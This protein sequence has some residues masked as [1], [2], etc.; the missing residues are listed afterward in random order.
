MAPLDE[1]LVQPYRVDESAWYWSLPPVARMRAEGLRFTTPVTVLVG[2]NGAGKS[3]LVEAIATAWEN[4]LSGAQ[5]RHWSAGVWLL[6]EPEAALSFSST[7]SARWSGRSW[8]SSGTGGRSSTDRTA[9]CGTCGTEWP[10]RAVRG[11]SRRCPAMIVPARVGPATTAP[12]DVEPMTET[13]LDALRHTVAERGDALAVRTRDDAVRW[14]WSE[15]DGLARRAA[16]GLAGLGVGHGSVVALLLDNRPEFHVADLGAVL[17][18]AATV[19]IYNTSS[20]EQ[21]DY[22]LRDSGASVLITQQSYLPAV[23]A[24]AAAGNDVRVVVLDGP[25]ADPTPGW[26]DLLAADPVERAADVTAEDLLTIIYT[27]GTTGPP[28]GVELTHRN[29]LSA[30]RSIGE[31]VGL[32]AG[33]RVICWLPLAHIAERDASYYLAVLYGLE[34]TTCADPRQVGAA[35]REVRPHFFFAVPRIWEKLKAGAEA[36]IAGRADA[37]RTVIES[38]VADAT[39]A[40]RLGQAGDPVPD[41]LAGR[42][43]AAAPVLASLRAALGLDEA[44][45]ANIGA[46]PSSPDLAL[47]FLALGIPLAE[48]YGMSENCAACTCNPAGAIRVGTAGPPL[49]GVELRI[50]DDGEVLM[51]S[52]AVMRGYRGKPEE[53]ATVLGADGFLRTGD[54]GVVEDGYLRIVDRKKEL[55]INAAGKNISPSAVEAAVK[56]RSPLI[57]QACVIGDGRSYNVALLVLDPEVAAGRDADDPSVTDEIAR[58]VGEGNRRLA[59]VEQVR[60]YAIVTDPWVP[61]GDELTPTMKLKRRPITEKYAETI[62]SL[63]AGGGVEAG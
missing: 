31:H 5:G 56:S 41:D 32:G 29:L 16:G 58:A 19:S 8:R 42:V 27:S 34:V 54:I 50:A 38:A 63:Y 24:A 15:L 36:S 13:L 22:V 46:A 12:K 4:S 48:I 43:A 23:E 33:D 26:D 6:D 9:T 55:I 14:T 18:G 44:R 51:R 57:G 35:L 1:V 21:I 59:R 39:E 30:N 37:E 49:P 10:G 25:A 62:E 45:A 53:T 20:P 47:F 60:R 2:E 17:L 11:T 3:T 28:K 7:G 52:D 61:G 40:A